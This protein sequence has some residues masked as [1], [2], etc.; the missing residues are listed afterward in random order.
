MS[1][2][3]DLIN[4][5]LRQRSVY[6][7]GL[8]LR[9]EISGVGF[10]KIP[11]IHSRN[12]THMY[13]ECDGRSFRSIFDEPSY[14]LLFLVSFSVKPPAPTNI[15]MSRIMLTCFYW[16]NVTNLLLFEDWASCAAAFF[17]TVITVFVLL[18]FFFDV[19]MEITNMRILKRI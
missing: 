10:S 18:S 12:H 7:Q 2:V 13:S 19:S 8:D 15:H 9:A 14:I 5:L 3:A 17:H 16:K 6:F 1:A 4:K 11:H